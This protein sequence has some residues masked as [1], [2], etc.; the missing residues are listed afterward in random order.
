MYVINN[1]N[2]CCYYYPCALDVFAMGTLAIISYT[3]S[4]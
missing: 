3:R 1:T 4:P 2:M